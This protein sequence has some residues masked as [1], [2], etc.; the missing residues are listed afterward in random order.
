MSKLLIS[1]SPLQVL[2]SLAVAIGLNEAIV[3][4][5]IHYW[6]V[7]KPRAHD[8]KPWVYNSVPE[9]K[10]QFPFWSEPTIRRILN[11]LRDLGILEV[12]NL[13][14]EPQDRTLWY[15]INYNNLPSDHIDQMPVDH[16]INLITPSDHIDQMDLIN[17]IKCYRTETNH[18]E[19]EKETDGGKPDPALPSPS[20]PATAQNSNS[21]GFSSKPHEYAPGLADP[22]K[23]QPPLVS[24][25][26]VEAARLGLSASQFR[27]L[28]DAV[29]DGCGKKPLADAGDDRVIER[30]Q[31]AALLL[32]KMGDNFKTVE[33]IKAIFQSW[34][35]NDYRGDTVPS[36]QQ[37]LDHA[38]L[39]VVGKVV[40][41]RKEKPPSEIDQPSVPPMVSSLPAQARALAQRAAELTPS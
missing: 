41:T 14:P 33:G 15:T 23:R 38:S 8:G 9:W 30:A 35:E 18:R 36:S 11:R 1:E 12:A 17:V 10:Q 20:L 21:T 31:W 32:V 5:Q 28:A 40:C 4:Q 22:R 29:I 16:L 25:H 34:R 3:L 24:E 2:P 7:T 13:S 19:R 26:M 6:L 37:L 39:M 27:Q